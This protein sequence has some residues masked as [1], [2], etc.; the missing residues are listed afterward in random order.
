MR[1]MED[2]LQ[3]EKKRGGRSRMVELNRKIRMQHGVKTKGVTIK[4]G[5]I[6]TLTRYP[7]SPEF[8]TGYVTVKPK[9]YINTSVPAYCVAKTVQDEIHR[10]SLSEWRKKVGLRRK[11]K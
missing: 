5:E 7:T 10:K 6:V 1:L 11:R 9:G 2:T 3:E 4:K 8:Y